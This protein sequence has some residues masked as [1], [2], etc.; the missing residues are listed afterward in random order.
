MLTDLTDPV[1]N[2]HAMEDTLI[3]LLT[4]RP[5]LAAMSDKLGQARPTDGAVEVAQWL[6]ARLCGQQ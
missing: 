3:G 4:D 6:V 2:A 1:R 5:Q